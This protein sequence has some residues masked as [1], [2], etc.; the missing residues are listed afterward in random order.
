M[1]CKICGSKVKRLG[2]HVSTVHDIEPKEYYDRYIKK[3]HEGI[4]TSCGKETT[5]LG[6]TKGYR[7]FCSQKCSANSDSTRNKYRQTCLDK[8]GVENVYQSKEI[9]DKI[10]TTNL[11]RYGVPYAFQIEEVQEKS[12]SPET[13]QKRKDTLL[14]KYGV[15][16]PLKSSEIQKK[17]YKKATQTKL[18]RYGNENYNNS[19]I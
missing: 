8:Y 15:D 16:N 13:T 12:R 7:K 2:T 5:F 18:H 3:E 4:C 17:V 6:I 10:K 11:E 19:I 1:I 14:K 9:K